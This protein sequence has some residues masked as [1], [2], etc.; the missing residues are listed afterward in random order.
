MSALHAPR[1][2][3]WLALSDLFLDTETRWFLPQVAFVAV[4]EGFSWGQVQDALDYEL[5]PL[6]ASNLSDIAGE[7]AG[8][9]E[10]WL[11]SSLHA[12]GGPEHGLPRPAR[13]LG[14]RTYQALEQLQAY[15]EGVAPESRQH[16]KEKLA[17]LARLSLE[18]D[19]A[20]SI[21]YWS[22]LRTL[23]CYP[24]SSV[25]QTFLDAVRP[26]YAPFLGYSGDATVPQL[27]TN[28]NQTRNL[29][30]WLQYAP[31]TLQEQ[32]ANAQPPVLWET[33]FTS[34]QLLNVC[35]KLS[36]LFTV[37][38]LLGAP[39]GVALTH[40]LRDY[41]FPS[42]VLEILIKGPLVVLYGRGE[43]AWQVWKELSTA[44]L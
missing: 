30:V 19:W 39:R 8:F 41:P 28:W 9:P 2:K 5:T 22:R 17:A 12:Q 43:Q 40:E 36:E 3:L 7:W 6:L 1:E 25:E 11:L 38:K 10:D 44:D 16:E 32:L 33:E 14:Q 24:W 29:L 15:F 21:G 37:K 27:N 18:P 31:E 4:D 26:V 23:A 34:E 35:E 13:A 42:A 20:R